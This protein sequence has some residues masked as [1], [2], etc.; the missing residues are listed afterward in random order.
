MEDEQEQLI[1]YG[2]AVKAERIDTGVKVGG[3]LV[4]FGGKDLQGEYFTPETDFDIEV[5]AKKSTF[6]HHGIDPKVGKRKIGRA[7]ITQDEVGLWA[8]TILQERD[9]YEKFIAEL[10]LSGKLGWSSGTAGHL[11]AR[12]MQDDGRVKITAWPIVEAS[13]THTPAEPRNTVMTIK[14]LLNY[15]AASAAKTEQIITNP[16]KDQT[17]EKEEIKALIDAALGDVAK[18]AAEEALKAHAEFTSKEVKAGTAEVIEDETDKLI[19]SGKAFKSS[20]EYFKLV[21]SAA[22]SPSQTDKRLLAMKAT[23]L[24]EATPSQGGFLVPPDVASGILQNMW[25]VGTVLSQFT[26]L[27]VAGNSM[28]INAIDET[29][30]TDGSRFGG[31]LGYWLEEG[32]TKTAT[33]PK[34]RQ[35][36]LVLKKVAALCYATDELIEDATALSAWLSRY[37]PDELRFRVEDSIINGDGVGKPFG[38]LSSPCLI[39]QARAATSNIAAADVLEMWSRRYTGVNDYVWFANANIAPEIYTMTIGDQPVYQPPGMMSEAPYGRLLGRPYIETEYNPGL[40]TAGDILLVS[41]SQYAMISK[42]GVQAAS[43]IHVQFVTD[44]TAFRF[45]YRVDG[46]PAW[47]SAVT[48]FKSSETVSPMVCLAATTG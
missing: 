20:A 23:G 9:E 36:R 34:F 25:G 5:P 18:T 12:E 24:N 37:V 4:R 48:S 38:I 42:G 26:S 39:S 10:A 11:M 19:A 32:G 17:M 41:P 14:S 28:L 33:K 40:G 46:Q 31:V 2:D 47:N 29:S 15:E 35:I 21:M 43:S 8:E 44:E 13:L 3:Y 30:R 45:V 6:F 22:Y 27:P 1:Y 16:E 7:Q